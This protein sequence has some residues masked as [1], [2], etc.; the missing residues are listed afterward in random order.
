MNAQVE[1]LLEDP[2]EISLAEESIAIA[3]KRQKWN[4][5]RDF[6]RPV[7]NAL[8]RLGLEPRL[9]NEVDVSFAG[10]ARKLAAVVRILRTS[11]F[12]TTAERPK[13]G[14]NTWYAY[15]E[16]PDCS[17]KI[18]LNFTSSVCRRVKI[19]TKMV[20]QDVYEVQCGDI[21]GAV[22]SILP[23]PSAPVLAIVQDEEMPF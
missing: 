17:T 8:Q 14:S 5:I 9:S 2:I 3:K 20:E 7:I 16:H 15:Y 19:G 18:W 23:A 13:P 1:T 6:Y 12:D 10:D 11:G 4:A 22:D 21:G